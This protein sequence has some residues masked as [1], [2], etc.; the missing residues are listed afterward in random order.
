MEDSIS[1]GYARRAMD[2][3][4]LT[5]RESQASADD[6]GFAGRAM[7]RFERP[8][9]RLIARLDR[10]EAATDDK[11]AVPYEESK[12]EWCA[13]QVDVLAGPLVI[14]AAAVAIHREVGTAAFAVVF[15]VGVLI[16]RILRD[17][18]DPDD[19]RR[20]HTAPEPEPRRWWV[21]TTLAAVTAAVVAAAGPS[22]IVLGLALIAGLVSLSELASEGLRALSRRRRRAQLPQSPFAQR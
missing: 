5:D 9:R 7:D 4:A 21:R 22:P 3:R 2:R 14:L 6:W 17:R 18:Y 1:S 13:R 20:A 8:F 16:W 11:P 12:L 10:D 15:A 19:S